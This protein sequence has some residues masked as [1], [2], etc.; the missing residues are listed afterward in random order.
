M[1]ASL[2]ETGPVALVGLGNMGTAV[3]ERLLDAG[4]ELFVFN[5]SGGRDEALVARGATRLGSAAETLQAAEVCVLT[6]AD[7]AAVDAVAL[8]S[9][10]VLVGAGPGTALIE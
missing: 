2:D 1:A 3:G 9:D 4:A 6:L 7:D 8:G 5:R 10:G